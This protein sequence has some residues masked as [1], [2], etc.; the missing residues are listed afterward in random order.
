VPAAA[1]FVRGSVGGTITDAAG[2][3]LP[4]ASVSLVERETNHS[5]TASTSAA[6]A[7]L[8]P[9]LPPGNYRLTISH[10]QY[11][12]HVED[13][14]LRVNQEIRVDISLLAG[15]RTEQVVVTAARA[16]LKTENAALGGVIEARQITGLPLDGRNFT[17]LALLVPGVTPGAQGSA[18]S[19]RG[20]LAINVNGAREDSNSFLLDGVLNIDPKLNAQGVNPPVDAVREFEVLTSA[21][22]AS[23]A[24]NA[25]G[26]INAILR[27]G[28]NQVHGALY[29]FFR[30]GALDARNYFAPGAEAKPQ[31]LRNQFGA[32]VGGPIRRDRAFFFADYEGRR[33]REGITRITNVPTARERIGD[34]SESPIPVFDPFTQQPFPANRIPV[35]RLHPVGAAIAALYPL[36]NRNVPGQNFVSSPSLRDRSDQFDIRIDH[37]LTRSSDL[38]FRYSFADRALYEPFTGPAFPVV[39]GF[40]VDVPRRAHNAM[41]SH[42]QIFTPNLLNEL[43]A[44]FNR[45]AAGSFHENRNNDLNRAVGLPSS[46]ARG[47]GLS[48]IT[49]TGFSPLGDEYNNPQHSASNIY[50]LYDQVSWIHGRHHARF[51]GAGRFTQQNGFRDIQSRGFLSFLGLTGNALAEL[52]QG[53]PSTTGLARLDNHQ[54]LRTRS[55][56]L[57]AQDNWRPR[58]D[59]TV[60]AGLRYEF[61]SPPVDAEDRANLFD[62]LSRN[63]IRVGTNGLPRSGY[64]SDRN[65]VG[66]R[67]GI[68]WKPSDRGTVLRAGYGLY[69]DQA[70][71]APGEGLYFNAPYFDF[72]FFFTLDPRAPLTLSDPF[73]AV[74]PF[75]TPPSA[76]AYQ[77][78]LRTPYYQHWN[79]GIQ[80][81]FGRTRIFEAAY[82]GSKGTRLL[83]AR[84]INQPAP[85]PAPRYLRPLPQFEDITLV[86]SRGNSVY[87]SLQTRFQQHFAKGMTALAAYTWSKSI[88]D[89]SSFFSSAGDSNFPQD[90]WNLRA[91]R[92]LSNFDTPQRLVLSYSYDVPFGKGALGGWQTFGIW[93][94]QSGRPFTVALLPDFDNSNTGRSMLGF[95]S[96]DR[97]HV[98]RDPRLEHRA[99]E[100]WFDTAAFAIPPRGTFGNAGRNILRGPAYQSINVSVLKNTRLAEDFTVQLRAEAFNLCNRP[101]LGLP[102][103]FVG[104]PTFGR[105]L[106]AQSPRHIQLGLKLLF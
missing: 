66:P 92:G 3:A 16:L 82:A 33:V 19:V 75:A 100:R 59:L 96:N 10:P 88:D 90:S 42:T 57:F 56:N 7:F 6:G 85:S 63:L 72:R 43:R 15:S 41:A 102:D 67:L 52:L 26:Q 25:G 39:P 31:Y 1:Q 81:Q 45:V 94:F 9:S 28:A 20:D 12:P 91:E 65:N 32:A 27:S 80:Q 68:A 61:N 76:L 30:N 97:P 103:V 49:I 54:H 11:R 101:N 18:G 62:P 58:H 74:F 89:A 60:S 77:R 5:R 51:G 35:E 4:D 73:P 104:S 23:F 21:Y 13:L 53:L 37:A 105:I 14:A 8:L 50:Q 24:R 44:G 55:Y 93:T 48:Y 2:K 84:D 86:E 95:G 34:F 87:H 99:P 64:L 40:G 70:A 46:G 29:E 98:L 71:L 47:I 36:P 17:E 22:D 38:S 79:L 78:D 106:T 83:A 69:Y